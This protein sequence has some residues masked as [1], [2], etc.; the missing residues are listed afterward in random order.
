MKPLTES[1][2]PSIMGSSAEPVRRRRHLAAWLK[3]VITDR[4]YRLARI[5]SNQ[6]LDRF[7]PLFEGDIVNVSGWQDVDKQ[8]RHYSDYFKSARSYTITNYK[9]EARGFQGMPGEIFLDL[10]QPLPAELRDRFDVV[11]N[12]TVLEHIYEVH[13]AFRNLCAM[14]KD[15]VVLVVPFLQPM[16]SNYGDYWRFSPMAVQRLFAENGLKLMYC[17][18]NRQPQAS[19]YLFAIAAKHP[20][21]W[22]GRIPEQ[23]SYLDARHPLDG[24]E[25]FVG[26]HAI[27]N[28]VYTIC[29]LVKRLALKMFSSAR[30]H[31]DSPEQSSD[32][33]E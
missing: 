30:K 26:C 17:S 29:K 25:P 28:R 16:H 20:E 27:P 9:S 14:S 12:H 11:F 19:I 10:I 21:R 2:A 8:G 4:K 23:T 5:W 31:T 24:F 1:I 15:V 7:A 18:F 33:P 3:T 6:E 22:Q 13:A 32:K